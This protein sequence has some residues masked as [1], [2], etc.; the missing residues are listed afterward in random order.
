MLRCLDALLILLSCAGYIVRSYRDEDLHQRSAC[1][2][3][4]NR[5]PWNS[6]SRYIWYMWTDSALLYVLLEVYVTSWDA[7]NQIFGRIA[8]FCGFVLRNGSTSC[9]MHY[10]K[11]LTDWLIQICGGIL[12]EMAVIVYELDSRMYRHYLP[13][14][15][16]RPLQYCGIWCKYIPISA[17]FPNYFVLLALLVCPWDE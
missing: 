17:S 1:W 13:F 3:M 4:Y 12:Y 16:K 5:S 7:V 2:S 8:E 10:I 11:N 9:F 14:R 15:F 6:L